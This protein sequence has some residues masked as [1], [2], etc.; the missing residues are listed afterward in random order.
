M[1]EIDTNSNLTIKTS[2]I[3]DTQDSIEKDH[4]HKAQAAGVAALLQEASL[5]FKKTLHL[6]DR[7]ALA[8]SQ[9]LLDALRREAIRAQAETLQVNSL[10]DL[11]HEIL[12][13]DKA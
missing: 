2:A 6:G 7:H 12:A 1:F 10:D 9:K 11:Q 3:F 5:R 13:S 4:S 8:K